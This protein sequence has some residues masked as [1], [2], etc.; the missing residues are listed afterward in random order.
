MAG[1]RIPATGEI[2]SNPGTLWSEE[3]R[4]RWLTDRDNS[5]NSG[6]LKLR[7]DYKLQSSGTGRFGTLAEGDLAFQVLPSRSPLLGLSDEDYSKSA[8]SL[9]VEIAAIKAVA[10]VE[11]NGK[12]FDESSRPRI[13]FERHYFHRLTF[14]KYSASHP[15]I[16]NSLAGGYGLF[17]VQYDKLERAFKLDPD[18]ALRSASWGRFQIMGTTSALLDLPPSESSRA[19]WHARNPN[20]LRHLLT[21][22][23][24]TKRCLPPCAKKTG[25]LLQ[26]PTT[27]LATRRITMTIKWRPRTTVTI[28]RNPQ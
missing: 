23:E 22:S 26:A 15:D 28:R 1:G 7:L 18:A 21:S 27:D 19:R 3:E 9:G 20:T 24:M 11:T 13:L 6:S 17:A 8:T 2:V 12:A 14:G 10:E 16:S 4:A 5:L 25:Q